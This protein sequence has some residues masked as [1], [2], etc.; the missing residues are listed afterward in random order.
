[1]KIYTYYL[2]GTAVNGQWTMKPKWFILKFM[3]YAWMLRVWRLQ[4]VINP[5]G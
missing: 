1:M 3:R 4:I 2:K 5:R